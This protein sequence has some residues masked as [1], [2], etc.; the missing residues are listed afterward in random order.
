MHL[1]M[2]S[3][4]IRDKDVALAESSRL[5]LREFTPEDVGVLAEILRDPEVMEF[6]TNGPCSEDDTRKFI[7]MCRQSYREHGFG[8][9]AVVSRESGAVIGFCGLSYVDV[10]GTREIEIGYRLARH[11]W[12]KGLATE[13]ADTAVE[14][15]FEAFHVDSVIAII[16]LRHAASIRVAEKI[17][18]E[19][20]FQTHYCGWDVRI[21]RKLPCSGRR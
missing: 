14:H 3:P 19:M 21:Y 12:G 16:A 13:A 1:L 15:G 17:G 11:T 4:D 8:Q 9:W 2:R 18:F 5:L 7:D 6:S 20:G 10:D